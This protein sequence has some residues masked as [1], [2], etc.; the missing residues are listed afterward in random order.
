MDL[1]TFWNL[2]DQS[3]R[4]A[5]GDSTVQIE[6]LKTQLAGLDAAEIVEF[7]RHLGE[8]HDRAYTW[9]LW[10]AAFVIS[11]GC[12][13]DGFIDFRAW[14]I[15]RGKRVFEAALAEPDSLASAVKANDGKCQLEAFLY[16]ATDV[17]EQLTS[18]PGEEFPEH[19]IERKEEPDGEPWEED[20]LAERLPNLNRKFG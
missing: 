20:D 11:G 17:W 1:A 4:E 19:Q 2:I 10:G 14:L 13:D 7:D 9:D 18:L 12:S 3:R 16:L 5:N 6:N 8:C 15:S